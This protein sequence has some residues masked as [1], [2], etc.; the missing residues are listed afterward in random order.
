MTFQEV[1]NAEMKRLIND[2]RIRFERELFN[3]GQEVKWSAPRRSTL[4]ER[5]RYHWMDEFNDEDDY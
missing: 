2:V 1:M 3:D 5:Y 4:E